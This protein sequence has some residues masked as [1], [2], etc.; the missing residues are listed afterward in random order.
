VDLKISADRGKFE[1]ILL[2]NYLG[3]RAIYGRAGTHNTRLIF[4]NNLSKYFSPRWI[5]RKYTREARRKTRRSS[6]KVWVTVVRFSP[7]L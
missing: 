4:I 5:F 7:A 2:C 6:C 3:N 1:K